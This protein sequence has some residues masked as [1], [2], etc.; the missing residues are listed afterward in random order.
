MLISKF[1]YS[2][3]KNGVK[4]TNGIIGSFLVPG[5]IAGIFSAVFQAGL[6]TNDGNYN[7]DQRTHRTRFAQGGM[8][9]AGLALAIGLG[10]FTGLISGVFM[11]CFN[12][13]DAEDQFTDVCIVNEI[14]DQEHQ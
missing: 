14:E 5:I 1:K 6:N 9:I 3:N 11:G 12:K 7:P 10:I 13:R 8:Q 4:D 2:F